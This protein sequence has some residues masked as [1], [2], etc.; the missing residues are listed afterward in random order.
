M[1]R[2]CRY[3]LFGLV[4]VLTIGCRGRGPNFFGPAGPAKYQRAQAE[5]FDPYVDNDI[6]PSI[7]DARPPDFQNPPSEPE[8]ARP[9]FGRRSGF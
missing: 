1:A 9:A 3:A 7:A 8:R 5:R 6:G 4:V 2:T